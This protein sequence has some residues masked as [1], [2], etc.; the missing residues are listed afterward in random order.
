M[1]AGIDTYPTYT[2]N[3]ITTS[4][5]GYDAAGNL[6]SD[7][8]Q[9]FTYNAVGQQASASA[10]SLSQFYDGDQLRVKKTENGT[11]TYYLRSSVLGN[12]VI[13]EINQW[14]GWYQGYV[15]L[16]GE[17]IALQSN[18]VYWRHSDP[19]TKGQRLTNSAGQVVSTVELD[20]FGGETARS[21]N[22][23]LQSHKFTTYERDANS[24]DEAQARRYE[25]KHQRFAQPDP[26]DGSYNLADPQSLNRYSYVENDPVNFVDPSGL[27]DEKG[28]DD[29]ADNPGGVC[30]INYEDDPFDLSDL[31]PGGGFINYGIF[32][33]IGGGRGGGGGG[34]GGDPQSPEVPMTPDQT[35][36]IRNQIA[37][38]LTDKCAK[39]IDQLVSSQ[40][41]KPYDS[42]N[43]L[44][45]DF[46]SIR[47]GKGG[48]FFGGT[49]YGGSASG[50][51]ANGNGRVRIS[52]TYSFTDPKG[53]FGAA[54]TALHEIIHIITGAGDQTLS[55]RVRSLGITV[56][57]YPG[58]TLPFPTDKDNRNLAYSGYWG[59][60]LKNACD[61]RGY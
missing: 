12:Q 56:T 38:L 17:M 27:T 20:P 5:F 39:F 35:A 32:Y 61:P 37:S 40:T 10:T 2:N 47:D 44:L 46:N 43:A 48:F 7:G 24:G 9:Q 13:C 33:P 57:A 14:G 45:T 50:S 11:T 8:Q 28:Q 25:G 3:R 42:K 55:E 16:G 22:S 26:W 23:A 58:Y 6:T 1:G 49:V 4:G 54:F 31:L 21:V 19:V 53:A 36:A 30:N 41:G 51:F 29:C 59:Q 60:A 34:T 18:G 15:Y 52:N